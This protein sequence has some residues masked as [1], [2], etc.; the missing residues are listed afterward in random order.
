MSEHHSRSG[1]LAPEGP[2]PGSQQGPGSPMAHQCVPEGR[3]GKKGRKKVV[4]AAAEDAEFDLKSCLEAKSVK[5]RLDAL[6]VDE[7]EKRGQCRH[8]HHTNLSRPA[9]FVCYKDPRMSCI[10]LSCLSAPV[11]SNLY[12]YC[13]IHPFRTPTTVLFLRWEA[14]HSVWAAY[15]VG[16]Y[17]HEKERTGGWN[18]G[19]C[20]SRVLEVVHCGL[21]QA[22]EYQGGVCLGQGTLLE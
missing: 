20:A 13:T 5:V 9:H 21:Y 11:H 4:D 22:G 7:R 17:G 14:L 1:S 8:H 19:G 12:T 2:T 6:T 18:G 10:L 15:M 3:E 16:T